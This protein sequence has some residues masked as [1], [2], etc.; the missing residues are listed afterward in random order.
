[1]QHRRCD[2]QQFLYFLSFWYT[3]TCF[4]KSILLLWAWTSW[5][6]AGNF[7][8]MP[9]QD[10]EKNITML[11]YAFTIVDWHESKSFHFVFGEE[12]L[13]ELP[14][15]VDG[16]AQSMWQKNTLGCS[17]STIGSCA[18]S[19]GF[20]TTCRLKSCVST[21]SLKCLSFSRGHQVAT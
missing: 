5:A 10:V 6:C 9:L 8:R 20:P 11:R 4:P 15:G 1:M 18:P 21:P 17:H 16:F 14:A 13:K 3:C 19:P 7:T 2:E 12:I